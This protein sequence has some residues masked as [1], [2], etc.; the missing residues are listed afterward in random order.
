MDDSDIAWK[1]A[2]EPLANGRFR[3]VLSRK[4]PNGLIPRTFEIRCEDEHETAQEAK[5]HAASL[6]S[7]GVEV[8]I[9]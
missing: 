3:G 2:A 6:A 1:A 5:E 4:E 9:D 7:P 8:I